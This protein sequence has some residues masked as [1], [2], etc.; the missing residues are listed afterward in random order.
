MFA[1]I[2]QWRA[3][4]AI[5][6]F[7]ISHSVPLTGPGRLPTTRCSLNGTKAHICSMKM[8]SKGFNLEGARGRRSAHS[9]AL[10]WW[11][12]CR[13]SRTFRRLVPRLQCP[14][15]G[16]WRSTLA[17]GTGAY[18]LCTRT[19]AG[20]CTRTCCDKGGRSWCSGANLNQKD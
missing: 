11:Q 15:C 8:E 12:S 20:V 16:T 5:C 13:R 7:R 14:M 3:F 2:R 17:C 19:Q 9:G 4:C 6:S 10:L 18:L 1:F